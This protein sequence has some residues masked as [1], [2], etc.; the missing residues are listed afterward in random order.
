MPTY[1][2]QAIPQHSIAK[3]AIAAVVIT[4]YSVDSDG[5]VCT[6]SDKIAGWRVTWA[7][8]GSQATCH[9]PVCAP[10]HTQIF[11]SEAAARAAAINAIQ[12][13]YQTADREATVVLD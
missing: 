11:Q 12:R 5:E 6:E 7:N 13:H 9:S 3:D 4:T 8:P 2:G 1:H 10:N